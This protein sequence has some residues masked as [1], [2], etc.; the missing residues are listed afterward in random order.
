M[1]IL[2]I[3]AHLKQQQQLKLMMMMMIAAFCLKGFDDTIKW[4]QK[5]RR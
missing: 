5:F 3:F 4:S 1:K 2:D